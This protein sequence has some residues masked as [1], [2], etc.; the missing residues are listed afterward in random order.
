MPGPEIERVTD[1]PHWRDAV[2]TAAGASIAVGAG[3]A[4]AAGTSVGWPLAVVVMA[5]ALGWPAARWRNLSRRPVVAEFDRRG[6]RLFPETADER[7]SAGRSPVD[8]PRGL[9]R[10]EARRN[11]GAAEEKHVRAVRPLVDL[12]WSEVRAIAFWRR[13]RGLFPVTMVGVEPVRG[14]PPQ[15][16]AAYTRVFGEHVTDAE[17]RKYQEDLERAARWGVPAHVSTALARRS[18][19]FGGSGR[20]LIATAAKRFSMRAN[21]VDAR[22]APSKRPRKVY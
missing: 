14:D 15:G 11:L 3:V 6:V 20:G 2:R 10:R 7:P 17:V 19:P 5:A 4:A 22:R 8:P 12:P 9:D 13:R 16:R 1:R 18:V 21:V